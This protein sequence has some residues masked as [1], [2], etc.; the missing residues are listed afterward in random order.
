MTIERVLI[1]DDEALMR[2][3]LAETLKQKKVDVVTASEGRIAIDLI[4]REHFDLVITDMKMPG[5][6]G[7]DVLKSAKTLS[8]KTSR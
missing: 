5:K 3:F 8:P 7:M 4:K 1:V 6:S 2:N